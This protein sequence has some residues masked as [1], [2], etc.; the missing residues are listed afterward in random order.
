ALYATSW[1][2]KGPLVAKG[3]IAAPDDVR[4]R[5]AQILKDETL[6]DPKKLL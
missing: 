5:S 1:D 4:K 2:P 3:L 6:L